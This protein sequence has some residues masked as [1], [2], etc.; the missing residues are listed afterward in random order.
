MMRSDQQLP[1]TKLFL[2]KKIDEKKK[3]LMNNY[4]EKEKKCS[5]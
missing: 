1:D 2:S 5:A 3:N 4:E